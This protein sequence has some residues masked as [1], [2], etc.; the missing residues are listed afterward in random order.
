M[1]P[2][3]TAHHMAVAR[4]LVKAVIGSFGFEVLCDEAGMVV[5]RQDMFSSANARQRIAIMP[6]MRPKRRPCGSPS[7][8]CRV[9]Y[10]WPI[11]ITR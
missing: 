2:T 3:S 6:L 8:G 5:C 9:A 10:S 4:R 7:T 1:H 11:K